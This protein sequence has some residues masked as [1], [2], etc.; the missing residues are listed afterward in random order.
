MLIK[1]C[2]RFLSFRGDIP[3][4]LTWD[5]QGLCLYAKRLE[6]GRFVWPKAN[7]G[8]VKL[9]TAQLSMLLEG[10]DYRMPSWT[11]PPELAVRTRDKLTR[12]AVPRS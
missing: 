10:I 3:K 11:A 7:D 12:L 8:T 1:T 9:T 4:A 5:G 2:D 6:R